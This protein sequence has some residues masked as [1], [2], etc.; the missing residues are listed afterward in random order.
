[1]ELV[2]HPMGNQARRFAAVNP[3]DA[4]KQA[5]EEKMDDIERRVKIAL[6]RELAGM[7]NARADELEKR[8]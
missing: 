7:F 2:L 6:Y 4:I 5:V 8:P 1:M 3:L